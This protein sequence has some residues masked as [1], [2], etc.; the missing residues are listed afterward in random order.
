M[1]GFV[2]AAVMV[3]AR[4]ALAIIIAVLA[5][6]GAVYLVS[7]KL[8]N[9]DHYRYG[10]CPFKF[11]QEPLPC[12]PP[13]RAAWQIPLAIVLAAVGLG[14]GIAITSERPRRHAPS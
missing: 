13:T 12:S 11:T 7:N 8:N 2:L 9:P 1:K 10:G 6:A 14:A 4:Q 3:S 5:I